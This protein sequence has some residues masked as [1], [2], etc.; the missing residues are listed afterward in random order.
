M[1]TGSEARVQLAV[2]GLTLGV[3]PSHPGAWTVSG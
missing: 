3:I 2:L 1:G